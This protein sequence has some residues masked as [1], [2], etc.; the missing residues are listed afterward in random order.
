M[1]VWI[2]GGLA[3]AAG[4]AACSGQVDITAEKAAGSQGAGGSG[5]S[6]ASGTSGVSSSAG[7]GA[8]GP[9]L[10]KVVTADTDIGQSVFFTTTSVV[11]PEKEQK[12]L[13]GPFF[14][15]D[16][17]AQT[18]GTLHLVQGNDCG[19]SEDK[20][21]LLAMINQNGSIHGMRIPVLAGQ[22][23][24]AVQGNNIRVTVLG[25]RPY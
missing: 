8:P 21:I 10:T 12:V 17:T 22:T 15:T 24:C 20:L 19:V 4:I 9:G 2:I 6:G 16:A 23:V 3:L 18:G 14:I 1:K 13:E 11:S 5:S 25:F 7:T